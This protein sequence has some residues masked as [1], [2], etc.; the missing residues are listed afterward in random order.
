MD[1]EVLRALLA[2]SAERSFGLAAQRLGIASST[3]SER[4]KKLERLAGTTLVKRRPVVLT[5]A[6]ERLA[7][8]AERV[9]SAADLAVQRLSDIRDQPLA[10]LRIGVLSHG[11]GATMTELLR[12]FRSVHPDVVVRLVALDFSETASAVLD[13]QVDVAFVRPQLN[14]DR[15]DEFPLT[16]EQRFVILPAW[17]ERAHLPSLSYA[18]LDRDTFL[19]PSRGAPTAYRS[20]LHLLTERNQE[21]PRQF[22]SQCHYAEEFLTAVA[23]GLGVAT[24]IMS[25]THHYRWPAVS[26]VPITN[27][28]PAA[29]TA[30]LSH[31][32]Q[33][34]IVRDFAQLLAA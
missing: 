19:T 2:V 25:F 30:I 21:D 29:T 6:G 9:V 4:I 3:L 27:A 12:T 11:A 5:P 18:D 31:E 16:T 26:Y 7:A 23:A 14:D 13:G 8:A 10:E 1:T 34:T 22:D 24:T 20:F 33:R 32:D 17:D 28:L 15:F